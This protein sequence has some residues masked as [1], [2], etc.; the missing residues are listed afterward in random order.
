M[1]TFKY[2]PN[3]FA[4]LKKIMMGRSLSL[5]LVAAVALGLYMGFSNGQ[6]T[7][8][9]VNAL[10]IVLPVSILVMVIALGSGL[11]RG[12]KRQRVLYESYRLTIDENS[13]TREQ[14]NTPTIRIMKSDIT[15]I[16]INPNRSITI[17][18]R[19]NREVI[20]IA[21]QIEDYEGLEQVLRE[22]RPFSD[23]QQNPLLEKLGRYS[24]IITVLLFAAVF[25]SND[26]II[27]T[28]CAILLLGLLGWSFVGIRRSRHIDA[29]TK[30]G[31]YFMVFPCFAILAKLVFLWL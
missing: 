10:L 24:G 23:P 22:V 26:K 2:D 11:A 9:S 7:A 8:D 1:R 5:P 6:S 21:P 18:G 3:R 16:A 31:M 30:R 17:K 13:I 27:V 25:L 14:F 19:D 4:E 12:I 20:G 28:P 15:L 29:K